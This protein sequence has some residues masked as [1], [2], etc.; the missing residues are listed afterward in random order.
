LPAVDAEIAEPTEKTTPEPVSG[1]RTILLVG[2]D[3]GMIETSSE[4]LEQ[5][6][7][8]VFKASVG[9]DA[10]QIFQNR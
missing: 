3:S 7:F 10:L 8:I 1:K 6:G 9:P 5:L 4:L 2:D